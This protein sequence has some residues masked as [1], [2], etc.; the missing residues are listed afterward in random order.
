M[1][2][3]PLLGKFTWNWVAWVSPC[4]FVFFFFLGY[5][6]YSSYKCAPHS[7]LTFVLVKFSIPTDLLFMCALAIQ[8]IF[9]MGKARKNSTTIHQARYVCVR[10]L[11]HHLRLLRTYLIFFTCFCCLPIVTF[12]MSFLVHFSRKHFYFII[13]FFFACLLFQYINWKA[14]MYS[15]GWISQE[16]SSSSFPH[17][18]IQCTHGC[19][20]V[21]DF[22]DF[23]SPLC[24]VIAIYS[25]VCCVACVSRVNVCICIGM[26]VCFI[27]RIVT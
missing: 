27:E 12:A 16:S 14:S 6:T 24:T 26:Y 25:T 5:E 18:T 19:L 13:K 7:H 17:F 21:F 3:F 23:F 2:V 22:L 1:H 11:F 9:N 8:C 20:R 4:L 15:T 10:L